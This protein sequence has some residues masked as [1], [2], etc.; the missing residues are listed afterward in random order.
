MTVGGDCS[1]GHVDR[2]LQNEDIFNIPND[3]ALSAKW[4]IQDASAAGGT[5]GNTPIEPENPEE[6]ANLPKPT[7]E[8]LTW[9]IGFGIGLSLLLLIIML[10]MIYNSKKPK[11]KRA[12]VAF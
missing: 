3:V 1:E 7:L 10:V 2:M 12:K 9:F 4:G 8:N 6:I 5:I 11:R